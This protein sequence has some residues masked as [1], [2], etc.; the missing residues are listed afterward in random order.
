MTIKEYNDLKVGDTIYY[1]FSRYPEEYPRIESDKVAGKEKAA[2]RTLVN[3]E[4]AKF[5]VEY[6]E[7]YLTKAE[8]GNALIQAEDSWQAAIENENNQ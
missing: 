2:W 8:A 1:I 6:Q 7:A 3:L 4:E 5:D